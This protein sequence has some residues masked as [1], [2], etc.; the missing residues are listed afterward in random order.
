[1]APDATVAIEDHALR[2]RV[3]DDLGTVVNAD[4]TVTVN[5]ADDG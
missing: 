2:V 1:M 3:T 5:A 4:V